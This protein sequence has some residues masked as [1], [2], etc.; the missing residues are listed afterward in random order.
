MAGRGPLPDPNRR[1]TNAPTIPTTVLPAGGFD[2]PIPDPP[3][4][5]GIRGAMWWVW[6]WRT[7]QA[8]AWSSG[9]VY[10][11]ARRAG[12][13]DIYAVEPSKAWASEMRELDDRF[14]LTAKGMAA[15]RWTIVEADVPVETVD[16]PKVS[17]LKDRRNQLTRAS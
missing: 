6:A 17:S 13:E 3:V 8:A 9:D 7:P 12:I 4:E 16:D 11:L 15:L 5:L 14:G 10:T 1:R 2:G